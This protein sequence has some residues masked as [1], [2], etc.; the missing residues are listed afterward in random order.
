MLIG[1]NCARSETDI[2][3]LYVGEVKRWS[4][5]ISEELKRD[6]RVDWK[7]LSS[8][9]KIIFTWHIETCKCVF[10]GCKTKVKF[11]FPN[12]IEIYV[13]GSL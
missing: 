2:I 4:G 3:Y 10:S 12:K 13:Y 11:L 8:G 9:W 7:Y 1:G 5:N 6:L